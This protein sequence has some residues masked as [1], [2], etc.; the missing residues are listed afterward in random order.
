MSCYSKLDSRGGPRTRR[1]S[2]SWRSM[3]FQR[4]FANDEFDLFFD[5]VHF[6]EICSD[7]VEMAI[8]AWG[9]H[10]D[11]RSMKLVLVNQR[12]RYIEYLIKSA[13]PGLPKAWR[14]WTQ[15]KRTLTEGLETQ[16]LVPRGNRKPCWIG[17]RE[18]RTTKN[19][20]SGPIGGGYRTQFDSTTLWQQCQLTSWRYAGALPRE[21]H[22]SQ[23]RRLNLGLFT[24]LYS[25]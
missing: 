23:V 18:Q 6:W 25:G 13:D 22:V 1:I 11:E 2:R 7:I 10:R 24:T 8:D 3:R 20:S 17:R 9:T 19:N 15:F 12:W 5:Y 21:E 4:H 16:G 14:M